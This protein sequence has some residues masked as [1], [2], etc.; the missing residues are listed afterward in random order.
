MVHL[1]FPNFPVDLNVS[2]ITDRIRTLTTSYQYRRTGSVIIEIDDYEEAIF[3][4][5]LLGSE[6]QCYLMNDYVGA[7]NSLS[8]ERERARILWGGV[9]A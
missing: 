3:I 8:L 4:C 6:F 1:V 5:N 7:Y 2:D 9:Q